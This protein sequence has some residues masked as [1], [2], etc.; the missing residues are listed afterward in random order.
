LDA[1]IST[2]SLRK[3][4]NTLPDEETPATR[5]PVQL[6]AI[7]GLWPFPANCQLAPQRWPRS[8]CWR[9]R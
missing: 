3:L 9:Q 5:K 6:R 7:D 8:I 4:Q 1:Y 2:D